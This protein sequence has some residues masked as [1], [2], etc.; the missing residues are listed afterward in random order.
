MIIVVL[1]QMVSVV[2]NKLH[3]SWSQQNGTKLQHQQRSPSERR[4]LR[5]CSVVKLT[6][7]Y[8]L[9]RAAQLGGGDKIFQW[10]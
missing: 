7:K 9:L 10:H 6:M 4:P 1:E 3:G 2:V 8:S 5:T